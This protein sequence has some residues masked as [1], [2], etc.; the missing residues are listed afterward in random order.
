[1]NIHLCRTY[2]S[3]LRLN[4][5]TFFSMK[6]PVITSNGVLV[7]IYSVRPSADT[8]ANAAT[9]IIS[10]DTNQAFTTYRWVRAF[11]GAVN[12]A[13]PDVKKIAL[14]TLSLT[15]AVSA[16][17]LSQRLITTAVQVAG[18][19]PPVTDRDAMELKEEILGLGLGIGMGGGAG[20]GFAVGCALKLFA[21]IC[22]AEMRYPRE[23]IFFSVALGLLLGALGGVAYTNFID[24]KL[25][26]ITS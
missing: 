20:A 19:P 14:V 24:I 4:E 16:I 6:K 2:L 3:F 1:M 11:K 10:D 21:S 5:T 18:K 7:P 9:D 17:V 12:T 26:T 15:A 22:R 8:Q 23:I 25:D 13:L